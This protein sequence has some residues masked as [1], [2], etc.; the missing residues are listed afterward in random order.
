MRR[1]LV[2][3]ICG[4]W[5][6][7]GCASDRIPVSTAFDPLERFPREATFAWDREKISLPE[8]PQLSGLGLG[9]IIEE[10][11]EGAFAARGYRRATSV[12]SDFLLSYH[13]RVDRFIAADSSSSTAG[14]SLLL[15]D[16]SGRRVWT[17]W[18]RAFFSVGTE[19]ELRRARVR[20]ALDDMLVSF[21]P[22][23]TAT[24]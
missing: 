19:A 1:T 9:Q 24:D 22:S 20:Q 23:Q 6:A 14:L 18:G 10:E 16:S 5:L 7:A 2:T 4:L 8:D 3:W 21:P 12:D 11:A 13:L 17:G 15:T